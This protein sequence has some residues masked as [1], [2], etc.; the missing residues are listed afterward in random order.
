MEIVSATRKSEVNFPFTPL[1]ISLAFLSDASVAIRPQISFDNQLGLPTIYNDRIAAVSEDDVL[2]FV[3]DDVWLH[4]FYV[5]EHV[6]EGLARF[7]VVG[8]AGNPTRVAQQKAWHTVDG[9]KWAPNLSGAVAH[10]LCPASRITYFGPVPKACAL[11]DVV[12]LAAR[13]STL[14]RANVRFDEQFRFDFYDLDFCCAARAAGLRLGT[15]SIPITHASGGAFGSASWTAALP[16]YLKKWGSTEDDC[17]PAIQKAAAR[18]AAP[19]D[20]VPPTDSTEVKD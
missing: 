14:K 15:W 10:G 20:L 4:D 1:G 12:F 16:G 13:R 3:H 17:R 9:D 18:E 2:L 11:L 19:S 5:V 6:E 8:V 7:D